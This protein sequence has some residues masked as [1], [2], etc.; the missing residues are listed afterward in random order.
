MDVYEFRVGVEAE[1][2]GVFVVGIGGAM[3]QPAVFQRLD[4]VHGEEA[5]TDAALSVENE[6]EL[7]GHK[8][9]VQRL[10]VAWISDAGAA[11][12]WRFRG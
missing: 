7:F 3:G 11:A 4:E 10:E 9:G 2:R 6:V 8:V 5:F 1:Q 12:P